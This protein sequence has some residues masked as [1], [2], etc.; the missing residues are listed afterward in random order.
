MPKANPKHRKTRTET[1]NMGIKKSLGT[2]GIEKCTQP[3]KQHVSKAN[4][5]KYSSQLSWTLK[6]SEK[7]A[8]KIGLCKE[9]YKK[10]HKL[11]RK[12]EKYTKPKMFDKQKKPSKYKSNVFLE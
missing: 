12:E 3:V 4:I 5:E 8:R 11:Q 7:K 10:Y 2:C 9:H 1:V 6:E